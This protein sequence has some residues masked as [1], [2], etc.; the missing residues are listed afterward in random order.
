MVKIILKLSNEYCFK[1]SN[2]LMNHLALLPRKSKNKKVSDFT[3]TYIKMKLE[4]S[5]NI[6]VYLQ[7]SY[8]ATCVCTELA[9]S[10]LFFFAGSNINSKLNVIQ[11]RT[12]TLC[13][14]HRYI[15]YCTLMSANVVIQ[16]IHNISLKSL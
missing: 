9:H 14:I 1:N 16:I 8:C 3:Q 4:A 2:Q 11:A 15:L 7:I 13:T 12:F 10:P 5:I 6:A